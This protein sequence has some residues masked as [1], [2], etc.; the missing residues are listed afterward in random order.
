MDSCYETF[1]G[2]ICCYCLREWSCA[3]NNTCPDTPMFPA[4]AK[5][6]VVLVTFLI[7]GSFT[8]FYFYYIRKV[9]TRRTYDEIGVDPLAPRGFVISNLFRFRRPIGLSESYRL[10]VLHG[11]PRQC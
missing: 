9:R 5:W 6:W 11:N 10:S 7:V 1:N 4:P 3:V 2:T 8:S